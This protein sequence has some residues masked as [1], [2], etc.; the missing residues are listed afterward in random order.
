MQ[1]MDVKYLL[2]YMMR[3]LET[4]NIAIATGAYHTCA[5]LTGGGV[6]C[7]G[8]NSYGQLGTGDTSNRNSPGIVGGLNSGAGIQQWYT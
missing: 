6:N 2:M 5:V 4:G 8:F 7:W 3:P 1:M